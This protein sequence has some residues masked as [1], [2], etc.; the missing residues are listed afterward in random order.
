MNEDQMKEC[1]KFLSNLGYG[2]KFCGSA[3]DDEIINIMKKDYWMNLERI[4]NPE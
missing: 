1:R 3:S 2:E 4:R